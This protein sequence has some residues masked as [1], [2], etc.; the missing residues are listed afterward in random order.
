MDTFFSVLQ[1]DLIEQYWF[2]LLQMPELPP[3]MRGDSAYGV[4]NLASCLSGTDVDPSKG[5]EGEIG[6]NGE[7]KSISGERK[8]IKKKKFICRV[9]YAGSEFHG[10]QR[11]GKQDSVRTVEGDISTC[12]GTTLVA[13]GRT[14]KVD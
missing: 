12:L 7:D 14:D 11:Q 4:T 3:F 1:W 8:R 2:A 10:F 13:A 9:G 5:K 6:D